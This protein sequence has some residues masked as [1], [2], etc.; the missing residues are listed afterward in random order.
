VIGGDDAGGR[1][2]QDQMM[3]ENHCFGCGPDNRDGLQIKSFW[4]GDDTVCTFQP[5]PAHMAG[6]RHVLNGGI[7]GVIID[8][9]CV[10]TAI[11]ATHRAEGR[12]LAA[13]PHVWCVTASLKLDYLKPTPLDRPAVLRA[14]VVASERKRTTVDCTLSSDGV[15]RVRA[16]LIAVRV[17][18]EWRAP[19]DGS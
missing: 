5:R 14:R 17:P 4:D 1:A 9:H 7:I 6:P 3:I 18:A 19:V 11:A 8:C 12:P 10:C 2:I 15:E 13:E 16:Q